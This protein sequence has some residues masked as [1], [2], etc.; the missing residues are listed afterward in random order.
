MRVLR[1]G[2]QS[3]A[4]RSWQ[5][6]TMRSL[7]L[8]LLQLHEKLL[9][10][11]T[12]TIQKLFGI[13][14]KLERWKSLISKC[15]VSWPKIKKIIVLKCHLF[16][17][18]ATM[19]HFSKGLWLVMKTRLYMTTSND[20]LRVYTEKKLQSTSQSQ[21]CTQKRS[22][23]LFSGLLPGWCTRAFRIPLKP[24]HLRTMFS[25]WMRFATENFVLNRFV[26]SKF[27]WKP[28]MS[29]ATTGQQKEPNFS[30]QQCPIT[31]HTTKASKVAWTWLRS[32]SS[33]ALF[34]S[35]QPTTTFP[36]ILTT[37]L[38]GKC[39][40]NLQEAE[41]AF[42]EITEHRSMDFYGTGISKLISC[43]QKCADCNGFYFD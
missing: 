25:K 33:S 26:L 4:I 13:W 14:S 10:N 29:A 43:W 1:I 9:K 22:W 23:S 5:W 35:H 37:F 12:S 32:F 38:Q 30:P 39:F 21:S 42:Q 41:N 16:L 17:F 36:S 18:Y 34:T 7:M 28:A 2:A 6:P 24:L 27:V 19:N 20:Q 11:S 8:I 3:S 15:I 40:H 31:H